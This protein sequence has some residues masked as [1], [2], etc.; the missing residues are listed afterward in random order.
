MIPGSFTEIYHFS[1]QQDY[2]GGKSNKK[3]IV[4]T[5]AIGDEYAKS[6][7]LGDY[8]KDFDITDK[9]FYHVWKELI[10]KSRGIEP[11][12]ELTKEELENQVSNPFN[13]Q[14]NNKQWKT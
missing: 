5:E 6:P 13:N 1:Q 7:L 9:L 3:Y 11:K 12:R 4:N 14:P 2:S 8:V 10:D